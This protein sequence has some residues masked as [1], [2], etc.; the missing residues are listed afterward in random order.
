MF[1][2]SVAQIKEERKT[3]TTLNDRT[4]I[5]IFGSW[6]I[7]LKSEGIR[8]LLHYLFKESY[9]FAEWN[10]ETK[11]HWYAEKSILKELNPL[12]TIPYIKSGETVVSQIGAIMVALCL[13]AKRKDLMGVSKED[14]VRVRAIQSSVQDLRNI[15]W[16]ALDMSRDEFAVAYRERMR[17]QIDGIVGRLDG[18]LR[19]QGGEFMLEYLTIADFDVAHAVDTYDWFCNQVGIEDP[20]TSFHNLRNLVKEV[21]KLDRVEAYISS[22]SATSMPYIEKKSSV[23]LG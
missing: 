2:S 15:V 4:D 23:L 20:F 11:N 7:K 12:V 6:L 19:S 17:R 16:S 9:E 22:P 21:K 3:K 5:V 13:K 8:W 10:P 18:Q 1:R 14:A